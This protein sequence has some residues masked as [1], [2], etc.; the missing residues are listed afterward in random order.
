MIEALRASY[1]FYYA[2]LRNHLFVTLR[3]VS[4][5]HFTFRKNFTTEGVRDRER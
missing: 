5:H 1:I 4:H 2:G 3:F